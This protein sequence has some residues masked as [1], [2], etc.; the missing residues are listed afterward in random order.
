MPFHVK[1]KDCGQE[2]FGWAD[3]KV[4]EKCGG[5]LEEVKEVEP[6]N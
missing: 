2:Y 5:D 6:G 3:T 1:C 4:C